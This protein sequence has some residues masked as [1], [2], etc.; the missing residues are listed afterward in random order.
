[1]KNRSTVIERCL[2]IGRGALEAG[3][4]DAAIKWLEL[5]LDELQENLDHQG[6]NSGNFELQIRHTLG[7][8][9]S[10]RVYERKLAD[11]S[12]HVPI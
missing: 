4:N 11:M 1:L 7:Q 10:Q 12:Q 8:F 2:F 3:Q 9:R 5:A 6:L